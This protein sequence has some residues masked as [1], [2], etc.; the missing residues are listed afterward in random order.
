MPDKEKWRI[1]FAA[2]MKGEKREDT[3]HCNTLIAERLRRYGILLTEQVVKF[4]DGEKIDP[5][6]IYKRDI[7][8][9]RSCDILVAS[10]SEAS[11]GVG[12]E[13]AKAEEFR[14]PVLCLYRGDVRKL[15]AM[16]LGNPHITVKTYQNEEELYQILELI[17]QL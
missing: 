14:K 1:Y 12:Y 5:K 15:S 3:L 17:P 13:I 11:L 10:V 2:S 8:W 9:L 4:S 7:K 6:F 16:I